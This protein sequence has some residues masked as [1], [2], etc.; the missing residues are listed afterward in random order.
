MAKCRN[1]KCNKDTS[2]CQAKARQLGGFCSVECQIEYVNEV[3][4]NREKERLER[5]AEELK[6]LGMEEKIVP[7]VVEKKVEFNLSKNTTNKPKG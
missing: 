2:T 1:A 5:E 3:T 4:A 7:K 6:E